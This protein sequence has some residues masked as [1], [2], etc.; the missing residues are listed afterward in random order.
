M[1]PTSIKLEL[2]DI[3]ASNT[4]TRAATNEE[5]V[6]EYAAAMQDGAK[7]PAIV[8]FHDGAGY[9]IADGFHRILAA[10]QCGFKDILAEV[11][12]G[13]RKDAIRRG[14]TSNVTH[15]LK[16]T[17]ADKRRAVEIALQEWPSVSSREIA[18]LCGVSNVFV[19]NVRQVLT[20]N[21]CDKPAARKGA[22]GKT[23]PATRKTKPTPIATP[24]PECPTPS[25]E[26]ELE[27]TP[28]EQHVEQVTSPDPAEERAFNIRLEEVLQS[29]KELAA[30]FPNKSK[31]IRE[32]LMGAVE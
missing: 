2:L 15:G 19:E 5:T 7:F 20:V 24:E 4:Q 27:Q 23:Y 18:K 8:V 30:D 29:V 32:M 6:E 17:N 22:D 26:E 3:H 9:Y 1:I 21:T 25:D 31:H 28:E 14:L 13:T 10:V 12:P 16:R 11:L